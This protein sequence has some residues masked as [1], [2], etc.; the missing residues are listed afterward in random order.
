VSDALP[1]ALL[2]TSPRLAHVDAN[3]RDLLDMARRARAGGAELLVTPELSL[4]GYDLRDRMAEVAI[5]PQDAAGLMRDAGSIVVGFPERVPDGAVYNVAAHVDGGRVVHV[6]RKV[7]LPTYG[8]FDEGRVFA[9]GRSVV[10]WHAGGGMSER[11]TTDDEGRFNYKR[12]HAPGEVVTVSSNA[13]F[14]AF[15]Q[16]RIEPGEIFEIRFPNARLRTFAVHLA[17]ASTDEFGFF[18]IALGD[19]VVPH[20]PLSDHIARSDQQ[21]VLKPGWTTVVAN[22]FETETGGVQLRRIY[23]DAHRRQR[24][25]TNNNLAHTLNLRKLLL[26]NR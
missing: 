18:T 20:E 15:M 25:A 10:V 2:Q 24:A 7:F 11:L 4:S 19:L 9:P 21:A 22:V 1:I 6:H 26:E 14:Y 12:P 3:A 17:P 5:T 13:G 16:P 23:I 8:M